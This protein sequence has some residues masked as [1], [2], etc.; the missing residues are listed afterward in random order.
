[1]EVFYNS[2]GNAIA[3]LYDDK[4]SIYLYDG[5]P[6]AYLYDEHLYSYNGTYLGWIQN[7]L[8]Y[9]IWGD[10]S[11][12]TEDAS[13]GPMRPLRSMRPMKGMRGM[14]PMKGMRASR[15]SKPMRSSSWSS[16][17]D[18]QFFNQ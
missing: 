14:K 7:G 17:S 3:Y 10:V 18:E 2:S 5:T 9:D 12:F 13:G 16:L 6:V 8:V 15:P 4:E 11:F 1:M